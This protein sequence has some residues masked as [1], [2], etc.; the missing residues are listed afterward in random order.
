ML[1]TRRALAVEL[2]GE[3][4]EF[5]GHGSGSARLAGDRSG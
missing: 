3:R 4:S 1:A 5:H 2:V